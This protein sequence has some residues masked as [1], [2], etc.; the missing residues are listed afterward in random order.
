MCY[1][2]YAGL[3]TGYRPEDIRRYGPADEKKKE[4]GYGRTNGNV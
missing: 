1:Q 4:G 2:Q 3:C